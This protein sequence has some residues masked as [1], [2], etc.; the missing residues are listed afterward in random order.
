MTEEV[1]FARRAS[2]LVRE[3]TIQDVILWAFSAQ[4]ASGINFYSVRIATSN[5]GADAGLSFLICALILLPIAVT[6]AMLSAS[7]PRAGGP[8]IWVSRIINP[9]IGFWASWI[10][11]IGWGIAIGLLG[12]IVTGL[13]GGALVMAGL[14]GAGPAF[15][16]AGE[17]MCTA[18]WQTVGAIVW[19]LFFWIVSLF[20]A[21]AVKWISR[22]LIYL[23]TIM[24]VIALIYLV[25][26]GP[27]GAQAMFD[28]IW[29]AGTYKAILDAAT[30]QG[31]GFPGFSWDAT[32]ASLTI[33]FWAYTAMEA[34]TYLAGEVKSPKRSMLT[35]FTG[36]FAFC[37]IMYI[38]AAW[39]VY[40][41]YGGF[42]GAYG[43]LATTHPD[44]LGAIMPVITPSMPF[45]AGSITGHV[46]LGA[47]IGVFSCLWFANSILPIFV[48]C[49]RVIFALAFDRA[50]PETFSEVNKRGSPTWASHVV[51]IWGLVGVAITVLP[52]LDV[53][54]GIL[55]FTMMNWFWLLGLA[56]L[57]LPYLK[58][59][60][61]RR[62]PIQWTIGG[63]PIISIVGLYS[64][65]AGWWI[66]FFSIM[67]FTIDVA[68]YM[69]FFTAIGFLVYAWKQ[70][71]NVREGIDISKIYAGIPPE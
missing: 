20:G 30:K 58:P 10:M 71:K 54:L 24:V 11:V 44:V 26:V 2:G 53:I 43:F 8:Y 46:W 68:V 19:T 62:S 65:A 7:M 9:T 32:F 14:G 64:L 33:P 63:I 1:V 51:M 55:N 38:A 16:A 40:Y 5:P 4:V 56:A 21:K 39:A 18:T 23:P 22:I 29:G 50:L 48:V 13:L 60:I 37:G 57:L 17:A 6:L 41:A 12:F 70:A 34:I 28:K 67:D 27:G 61:F 52:G 49:S 59:E 3:L 66:A 42:I 47:A 31:W 25:G 69:A 35:G 15:V 36:G 45:F